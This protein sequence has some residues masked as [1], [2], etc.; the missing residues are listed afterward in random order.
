MINNKRL[1][2]E[3]LLLD[4]E[5]PFILKSKILFLRSGWKCRFNGVKTSAELLELYKSIKIEEISV[6]F[7]DYN[8]IGDSKNG[9][10]V[11]YEINFRLG[12][13]VDLYVISTSDGQLPYRGKI[14]EFKGLTELEA[15]KRAGFNGW[16]N[17]SQ[18]RLE[19]NLKLVKLK[20]ESK[21]K[22]FIYF[23]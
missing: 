19:E 16:V 17:K 23:E 21:N 22:E 11:G 9:V 5:H 10:D 6:V 8:L 7:C 12:N 18:L 1:K 20:V 4:D 13:G 3:I 2:C 15:A 14:E